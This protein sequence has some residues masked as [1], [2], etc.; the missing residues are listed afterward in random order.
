M[1]DMTKGSDLPPPVD[2]FEGGPDRERCTLC[3]RE[4][5]LSNL[6]YIVFGEPENIYICDKPEC[7]DSDWEYLFQ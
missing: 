3:G 2:V 1:F 7:K 6:A 4:V 5:A